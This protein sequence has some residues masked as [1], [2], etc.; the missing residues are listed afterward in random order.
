MGRRRDGVEEVRS[1]KCPK[2]AKRLPR[3]ADVMSAVHDAACNGAVE[4][5]EGQRS[6][7]QG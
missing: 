4:E 6:A 2:R 1:L 7:V 5:I 3:E